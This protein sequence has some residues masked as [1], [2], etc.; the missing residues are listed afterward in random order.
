M[1]LWL[2]LLSPSGATEMQEE[3][4]PYDSSSPLPGYITPGDLPS[5]METV[6]LLSG[7]S[8]LGEYSYKS[9]HF[10]VSLGPRRWGTRFP[11]YGFQ[12][13]VEGSVRVAK[14]CSHVVS[15]T[16][17]VSLPWSQ[18]VVMPPGI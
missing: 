8:H 1:A 17:T 16:A 11:I 2:P 10:C 6:S 12:D 13:T 9:D 7:G 14:K 3:L 18:L 4:P 5:P 15:V